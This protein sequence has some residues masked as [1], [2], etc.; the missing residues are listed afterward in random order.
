MADITTLDTLLQLRREMAAE[1]RTT[2][3]AQRL[4]VSIS[5]VKR[6]VERGVLRGMDMGTRWLVARESVGRIVHLRKT[7]IEMDAEGNPTPEEFVRLRQRGRRSGD[8]E[9]A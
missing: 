6:W 3:E 1:G 7:L 9:V 5:T 2:E 8:K 4:G